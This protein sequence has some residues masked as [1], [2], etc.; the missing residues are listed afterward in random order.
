MREAVAEAP[1]RVNLIGEH[2]DY[3]QGF[4]LPSIIPQR[5]R[6]HLV[7]RSDRKV[8]ASSREIGEDV[9]EF[10]VGAETV[11]HTWLDYIQGVTHALRALTTTLPGFDLRVESDIPLGSGLSS[12]AALEV[13]LLRALR[14]LY[15]LPFDDV[16]LA[17]IAQ[18]AETEFVGAPVGIMDQ[19]VCSLGHRR[20]ALFL[21]TRTL[22]YESVP[23]PAAAELVVIDSG[24]RHQHAGGAYA[25]RRRESFEAAAML[26]VSFLRDVTSAQLSRIATSSDTLARRARHI[27]SENQRVHDTVVALAAGDLARVG[28]LF[29]ASHES[30]RVDY[31][32]STPEIDSLVELGKADADVYGARL[33]GGGFGGSVVMFAK[34]GCGAAVASRILHCYE[35][36]GER[37][38]TI[39]LPDTARVLRVT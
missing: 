26:G 39:L 11:T 8:R 32:V 6:V 27:V 20:E 4:V 38:G 36:S 23:L 28:T 19:M 21:D 5:T 13:S 2:T 37:H 18:R 9:A 29:Y 14:E 12:S 1:G 22:S 3:H 33:T 15:D 10:V 7:A 35:Q 30:M 25:I 24:I 16:E 31:E 34:A 17:R